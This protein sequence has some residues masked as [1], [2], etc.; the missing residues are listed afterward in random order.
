M[1]TTKHGLLRRFREDNRGSGI[2]VVLASMVCVAL[3]GSSLLFLSYTGLRL[4]TTERQATRDFYSAE[5][6]VD[7]IRAGV[8]AIVSGAIATSY[9]YA[10]E[11][12]SSGA[13][14][15]ERFETRFLEDLKR[16]SLF[17]NSGTK[18]DVSVLESFV[19]DPSRITVE[20]ASGGLVVHNAVEDTL[21]LRDIQVTYTGTDD[22]TTRIR[23][24]L[25]ISMPE[26][27]YIMSATSISGLPQH[28]L[29]AKEALQ[30]NIGMTTIE[31]HG[32]AYAG[33]M[34]LGGNAGSRMTIEK[35]TL[36]CAGEAQV[37]GS[38]ANG[39]LTTEP[40]VKFW[41]GRIAVDGGSSAALGGETRVLDDLE[42][43]GSRASVVLSGSYYGFGDGTSDDG[44]RSGQANRSSAILVNGLNA[45]LDVSGLNRLMLAGRG[46]ISDSLYAGAVS[47]GRTVGMLESVSVRSNQQMYLVDPA[48]LTGVTQNPAITAAGEPTATLNPEGVAL[49]AAHGFSLRHL[50][51]FVPGGS[52][53][54]TYYFMEFRDPVAANGYFESYFE[55]NR[56]QISSYLT[57]D[58]DLNASGSNTLGYTIR[59]R[60]GN[61]TAGRPTGVTFDCT[62]MRSTFNQLKKTLIDSNTLSTAADPYE[63]IVD[64]AR[65]RAIHGAETFADETGAVIGLVTDGDYTIDGS[66][67]DLRMIIADGDVTVER[68]F[69]G[70]VICGGT[71][72]IRNS[73]TM[74]ADEHEVMRTF[75]AVNTD[76]PA[77]LLRSYLANGAGDNSGLADTGNTNAWNLNSLVACRNWTK[78]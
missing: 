78:N 62:G 55:K 15:T 57:T 8:Q 24:D 47:E 51:Y 48:Y 53:K 29:I 75:N 34:L 6:A 38:T 63:Y 20:A 5:T 61:Y 3:M 41:A 21:I 46:Y 37:T 65:V 77:D 35:G 69:R 19:S 42:L 28:A 73:V 40:S 2:V 52:Q 67:P 11:T 26:F 9:K 23:T 10:L 22:Y 50:Q 44:R 72:H 7:E 54:I 60:E 1:K 43:A 12:Y 30:Q 66:R 76:D 45:H 4:K 32:S 74:E 17:T 36:V 68:S 39:R 56:G 16:A 49:A 14:I 25:S 71:I 18:Y 59:G 70:L 64:T 33:T 13:H 58:S 31:I 27:A